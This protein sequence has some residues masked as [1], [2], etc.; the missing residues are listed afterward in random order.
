MGIVYKLLVFKNKE[1]SLKLKKGITFEV[2]VKPLCILLTRKFEII[3]VHFHICL[4]NCN[5]HII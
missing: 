1:I 4:Q 5:E 3:Q 2:S